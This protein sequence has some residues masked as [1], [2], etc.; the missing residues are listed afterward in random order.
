MSLL[1]KST[2]YI[3]LFN[4]IYYLTDRNTYI[5]SRN[6]RDRKKKKKTRT[7]F[8]QKMSYSPK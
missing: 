3:H 1:L 7:T 5:V 4:Q 2:L 6:T 8:Q